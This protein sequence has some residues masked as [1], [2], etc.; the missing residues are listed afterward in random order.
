MPCF[1]PLTSLSID[2]KVIN[3]QNKMYLN[4]DHTLLFIYQ[5]IDSGTIKMLIIGGVLLH[6]YMVATP[7][8][9]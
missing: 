3:I 7:F 1:L 9:F 2:S 5:V 8:S 6:M 4:I